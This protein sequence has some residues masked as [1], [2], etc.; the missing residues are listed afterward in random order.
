MAASGAMAGTD[1]A[2]NAAAAAAATA[3]FR[4]EG[5]AASA[6]CGLRS[7]GGIAEMT[8]LDFR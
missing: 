7:C 5:G 6:G 4:F 1:T 8:H 2:S 3:F